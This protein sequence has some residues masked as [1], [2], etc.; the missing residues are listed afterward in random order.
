M[1]RIL[2]VALIVATVLLVAAGSVR[3]NSSRAAA[4]PEAAVQAMFNRVQAR[5]FNGAFTYVAKSSNSN[6]HAFVYTPPDYDKDTT[7]RYP[8]LYLQHGA[9][10]DETGWGRQGCGMAAGARRTGG[11]YRSSPVAALPP[12]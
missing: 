10:E 6:R 9:G 2:P 12:T 1:N 11:T 5:D 4:T 7:K 8:V 3:G